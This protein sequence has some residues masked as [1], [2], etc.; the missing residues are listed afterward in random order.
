[1]AEVLVVFNDRPVE[2]SPARWRRGEA[3][4]VMPDGYQWGNREGLPRFCIVE[5]DAEVEDVRDLLMEEDAEWDLLDRLDND[6]NPTGKQHWK[7]VNQ[8]YRRAYPFNE[9][10]MDRA[11]RS[12]DGRVTVR[13]N[14]LQNQ[15]TDR[16]A[17]E[18]RTKKPP[19]QVGP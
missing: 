19:G 16:R 17:N 1:M 15:L 10:L 4:C 6:G 5:I 18:G 2:D 3:V 14:Q 13:Y 11:E 7:K 8:Y 12:P 9:Q